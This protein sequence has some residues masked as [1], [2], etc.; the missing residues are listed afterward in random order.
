MIRTSTT[1]NQESE[2]TMKKNDK[3]SLPKFKAVT[4]GADELSKTVGGVAG[5]TCGTVSV[6]HVDGTDDG[7]NA[8][9]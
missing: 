3:Q 2:K 4:L 6:C 8:S 1:H 7:D 5:C 9:L